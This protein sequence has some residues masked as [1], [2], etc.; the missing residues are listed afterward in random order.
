MALYSGAWCADNKP[1]TPALPFTL[2]EETIA[3][4]PDLLLPR[5]GRPAILN[6]KK[7]GE[8]GIHAQGEP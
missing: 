7:I 3:L 5:A 8:I 2:K 1:M 6:L 4:Y